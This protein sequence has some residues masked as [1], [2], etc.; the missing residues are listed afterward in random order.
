MDMLVDAIQIA[1]ITGLIYGLYLSITY[2]DRGELH[3][4]YRKPTPADP[5]CDPLTA[6]AMRI[7]QPKPERQFDRL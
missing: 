4:H 5:A 1:A 7:G 3:E 2:G 6:D